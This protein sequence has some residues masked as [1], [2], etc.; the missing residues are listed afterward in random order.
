MRDYGKLSPFFWTRG[1]GKRLRGDVE[2]QVV[3]AYISTAPTANLVGLY[4]LPIAVIAHETGM[5]AKR[6]AAALTRIEAAGYAKYDHEAELVWVPNTAKFEIG[7]TMKEGDKRRGKL[8]QELAKAGDHPFVREFWM[9]YGE[10]YALG[11]CDTYGASKGHPRSSGLFLSDPDPL[12]SP[13]PDPLQ[14]ASAPDVVPP[15]SKTNRRRKPETR[16]P[17]D[18]AAPDEIRTWCDGWKIPPNDPLL[19]VFLR[20]HTKQD[21]S[22]RDWAA[23]FRDWKK[24]ERE[25]P[26]KSSKLPRQPHDPGWLHRAVANGTC[27][28]LFPE[29]S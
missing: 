1:S 14:G 6:V 24:H 29:G 27:G 21:K 18:D 3:A 12:P 13:D 25:G 15:V 11:N 7:P 5:A 23:A 10:A 16:C 8:L 20:W 19:P 4:Y 9:V 28:D 2:A 17:S 26:I 22:W